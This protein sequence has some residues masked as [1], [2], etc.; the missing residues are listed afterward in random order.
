[1]NLANDCGVIKIQVIKMYKTNIGI[2]QRIYL[3][4]RQL[5]SILYI[6]VRIYIICIISVF[7]MYFNN[8]N[9]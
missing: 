3:Y 5:Y 1:M 8:M 7:F 4:L 2:I 6:Q 9:L